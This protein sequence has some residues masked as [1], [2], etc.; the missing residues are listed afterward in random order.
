MEAI[1][2]SF[3]KRFFAVLI[4]LTSAIE[5]VAVA[6]LVFLVGL[7]ALPV[8]IG[9]R[10]ILFTAEHIVSFIRVN[11]A[12]ALT[13]GDLGRILIVAA[14]ETATWDVWFFL[15]PFSQVGAGGVLIGGLYVGHV[16]E[17]N[18]TRQCSN[19]FTGLIRVEAVGIT[20]IETVTGIVWRTLAVTAR[21]FLPLF[22]LRPLGV[23]AAI[24]LFVGLNVEHTVAAGLR[25]RCY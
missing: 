4:L 5:T 23:V 19:F 9:I 22:D 1:Q 7:V 11:G 21:A 25:R 12:S 18:T 14:V 3:L 16:F 6:S 15:A 17:Q 2:M 10:F 20:V 13:G 24:V 8:A